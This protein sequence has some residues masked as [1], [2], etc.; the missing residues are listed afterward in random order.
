MRASFALLL[1][2]VVAAWVLFVAPSA[3]GQATPAASPQ[4]AS[5]AAR[6]DQARTHFERGAALVR[7]QSWEPALAEFLLS[8]ELFPTRGNTQNAAVCLRQLERYD[9]ALDMLELLLASFPSITPADRTAAEEDLR[10]LRMLVGALD[11]R[12]SESNAQIQ[13]D[14]RARGAS[15]LGKPVRVKAGSHGVLVYKPGFVTSVSRV[16]VAGSR[17]VAVDVR[18][19]ALRESG[20]LRVIEQTGRAAEVVVDGFVVGSAPWEG[21]VASGSHTVSLR[22]EEGAGTQPAQ[23]TVATSGMTP[24]TLALEAL[25]A[26][27]RVEP[28][29]SGARVAID[30]V[31]VGNGVWS[32]RVRSGGHKVEVAAEGFLPRTRSLL[33]ASGQREKLAIA[34]D[35]DP[36]SRMWGASGRGHFL[37]DGSLGFATGSLFGGDVS[38]GCGTGCSTALPIG[39]QG[40][41]HVGYELKSRVGFSLDGGYLVTGQKTRGRAVS[42]TPRGRAPIDGT[43]DDALA[44]RGLTLGGSVAY[45]TASA[46]PLTFRLGAGV[47][48]GEARD[49]RT[50]QFPLGP[51]GA[52]ETTAARYG[53]VAPEVRVGL[54]LGEHAELLLGAQ[55]LVLV[56]ITKPTW[57][58]ADNVVLGRDFLSFGPGAMVGSMVVVVTPGVGLRYEL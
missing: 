11:V 7:A 44:L 48:L 33:L 19:E 26:E 45:H 37:L 39:T 38:S 22:G 16:E 6:K 49:E 53:Y 50:A 3:R 1:A 20:R 54:P 18:L 58:D 24:L 12:V 46:L 28:T 36:E 43:A 42:A 30:G 55:A 25:D 40:M 9:E 5:D 14:Q 34:L 56:A 27:L 41:L 35:R 23:V 31:P 8:R 52:T 32:G 51:T 10:Q 2:A 57:Q 47:L 21:S 13:I 4:E 29:P 15:P 17:T